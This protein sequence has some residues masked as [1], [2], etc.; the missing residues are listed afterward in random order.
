MIR[1]AV[2]TTVLAAAVTAIVAAQEQLA[3]RADLAPNGRLRLAVIANPILVSTDPATGALQGVAIEIAEELARRLDARLDP[4]LYPSIGKLIDGAAVGEWAVA[5]AAID[6]SRARQITYTPSIFDE[7]I[8]YLVAGHS[9]IRHLDD[10]DRPDR[11]LAAAE[12]SAPDLY[13][14]R[15]LKQAELVRIAFGRAAAAEA[16]RSGQ[17]DAFAENAHLLSLIQADVPGSRVLEGRLYVQQIAMVVPAGR[18]MSLPY[19]SRFV[20]E[21]KASGLVRAGLDRAGIRGATVS[22]PVPAPA[23]TPRD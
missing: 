18:E 12:R 4:T 15:T 10:A 11:R 23:S 2:T 17:V 3:A 8:T 14:S 1:A 7:D 19:L 16:L 13:L 9:P 21:V 22:P 20:E 5:Y 6:P